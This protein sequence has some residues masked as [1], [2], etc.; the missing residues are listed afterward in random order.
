MGWKYRT[1]QVIT[2]LY[3]LTFHPKATKLYY[4]WQVF[5]LVLVLSAF[6]FKRTVTEMIK[7][8]YEL[9]A[10]GTAPDLNWIPFSFHIVETIIHDKSIKRILIIYIFFI[11]I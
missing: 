8:F 3:L 1:Q 7:H 10:A 11:I 4:L 6:P 5:W 9:T 2:F